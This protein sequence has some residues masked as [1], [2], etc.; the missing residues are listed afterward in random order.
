MLI[1]LVEVIITNK[2]VL[3]LVIQP[4]K[5]RE[6]ILMGEQTTVWINTETL[7]LFCFRWLMNLVLVRR[8][9]I[10]VQRCN[11]VAKASEF[12]GVLH[13]EV[14]YTRDSL[15]RNEWPLNN[16]KNLNFSHMFRFKVQMIATLSSGD[17]MKPAISDNQQ[18]RCYNELIR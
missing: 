18:G 6:A 17:T 2:N 14:K 3:H 4:K 8:K 15:W 1:S 16:L 9:C 10:L 12:S 11:L 5:R 13:F 7:F